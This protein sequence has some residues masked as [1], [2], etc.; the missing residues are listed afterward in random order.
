MIN[1]MNNFFDMFLSVFV[2][3]FLVGVISSTSVSYSQTTNETPDLSS[4]KIAGNGSHGADLFV[5]PSTNEI[6]VTY[7]QTQNDT[8]NLFF[9]KSTNDSQNFTVPVR[10]ND[11][12]GDVMWDGRVPPQIEVTDNGTIY[13]LWVSSK[14][15]PGFMYGFR[16]LKMSQSSDGGETF[17]SAVNVTNKD[18]APQAKAFQTF[19][20]SNDGKIYVG[21]LNYDVQ[22]L[23]NGTIISTDEENG[24]QASISVSSDGGNTFNPSLTIDKFACECC[25]VNVLAGSNGEDVYA[26]WRDKF[27]VL[28]NTDPQVDPVIRDMVVAHSADSGITF[29]PPN[30]IAN[31]SFVFGGCVHVGAPMVEDSKGTIHVVWYT[32]A[33]DHPGIYYAY[34]SDKAKSFSKPVVV[35]TGEWIPPLRSDIS[36]DGN[37]NIWITWEDSFGLTAL[38][39]NWKFENTSAIIH[40]G[41]IDNNTLVKFP[42]VNT[43]NGREPSIGTGN[44]LV[45]V[46]WNRDDSIN[47]SILRTDESSS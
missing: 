25:N 45:A 40:L 46:L 31:D 10:V 29:N 13:T 37:D 26:S 8:S 4:I 20:I 12:V 39:E 15:A 28:P 2:L 21:S 9:T 33:E 6:Y 1:H 11:K 43:E 36:V 42:P 23:D 3:I 19:D 14:D 27:P 17:T 7:I 30:K 22:I 32:G 5:D 24:T 47:L 16:T 35:L 44:G 34:S 38:D 18:D 41:K